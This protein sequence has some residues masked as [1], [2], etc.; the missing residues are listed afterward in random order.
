M[1]RPAWGQSAGRV[2]AVSTAAALGLGAF[3]TTGGAVQTSQPAEE[4]TRESLPLVQTGPLVVRDVPYAQHGS[5]MLALDIYWMEGAEAAPGLV[6]VHGGSWR[7]RSK[8]VWSTLASLYARA[9]Y[10]VFAIDYRLAPPGGRARFP[11]PVVDVTAAVDWVRR[12]ARTYRVDATRV[13]VGGSSAGAQL[14]LMAAAGGAETRPDAV[15]LFSPPVDL[16]RLHREDVLRRPIENYVGCSPEICPDTYRRASGRRA[17]D[18]ETPPMLVAYAR[19][20]LIPPDQPRRLMKRL[21][22]LGRPYVELE[23]AGK[24]HGMAV[25]SVT[26]DE[27]VQ[28]LQRYL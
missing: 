14:A 16:E 12:N 24:R 1:K 6:L 2:V 8:E 18:T 21:Q 13:A 26:V 11:D 28:F 4:R 9:G 10:V 17:V 19:Y 27:T 15:V 25:A 20:E 5:Q 3:A 7:R 23:L 22:T